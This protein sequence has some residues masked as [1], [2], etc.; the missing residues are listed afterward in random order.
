MQTLS[1]NQIEFNSFF[2]N[3]LQEPVVV[4]NEA[5]INYLIMP[6]FPNN[7]QEIFF[8]LFQSFSELQ[9]PDNS[10]LHKNRI[11]AKEFS[12]KWVGILENSND[13]DLKEN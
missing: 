1:I 3:S 11:T 10:I 7:W 4:K 5:G 8:M 2:Q 13:F 12:E 9:N 6:F